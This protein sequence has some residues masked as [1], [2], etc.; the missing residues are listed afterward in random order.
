MESRNVEN[1]LVCAIK[2]GRFETATQLLN[3]IQANEIN[4]KFFSSIL[5]IRVEK[6]NQIEIA[7]PQLCQSL[8]N[9]RIFLEAIQSKI[10]L[11]LKEQKINSA[12]CARLHFLLYC[13]HRKL[14][15]SFCKSMDKV[16]FARAES[17]KSFQLALSAYAYFCQLPDWSFAKATEYQKPALNLSQM[18]LTW[19]LELYPVHSLD[20]M[21]MRLRS[22]LLFF[23]NYFSDINYPKS[24]AGYIAIMQ[25]TIDEILNTD[26]SLDAAKIYA[27]VLRIVLCSFAES[28]TIRSE[29]KNFLSD[30]SNKAWLKNAI[31]S[32]ERKFDN[33]S[34]LVSGGE[35]YRVAS[36]ALLFKFKKM[37]ED[38]EKKVTHS[39]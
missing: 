25:Q 3:K 23:K 39:M 12:E 13:A 32:I 31:E 28:Q 24:D 22:S 16:Y 33:L 38:Q 2:E 5:L 4:H 36:S 34:A 26:V 17:I 21:Q 18:F 19:A 37:C 10:M 15:H 6:N 27:K 20:G 29:Y 9:F 7:P 30:E 11:A 8:V 35:N 1:E 14:G